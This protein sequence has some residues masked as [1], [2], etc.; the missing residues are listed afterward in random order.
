MPFPVLVLKKIYGYLYPNQSFYDFLENELSKNMDE[1]I[2]EVDD[3]KV[4]IMDIDLCEILPGCELVYNHDNLDAFVYMGRECEVEMN[5]VYKYKSYY[6][7]L[8]S[9]WDGE[10]E[11]DFLCNKEMI[12]EMFRNEIKVIHELNFDFNKLF[13]YGIGG[14]KLCNLA[15]AFYKLADEKAFINRMTEWYREAYGPNGWAIHKK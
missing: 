4:R 5:R 1:L 9:E 12:E 3:D 7:I 11:C 6:I 10:E 2:D 8:Y 14:K 15:E 13:E